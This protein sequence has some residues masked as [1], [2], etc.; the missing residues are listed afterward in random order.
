MYLVTKMYYIDANS[1]CQYINKFIEIFGSLFNDN[2]V[3][4]T[5]YKNC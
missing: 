3:Q 4:I 1:H 5:L 2:I